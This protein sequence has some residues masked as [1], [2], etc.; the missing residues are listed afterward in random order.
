MPT[1]TEDQPTKGFRCLDSIRLNRWQKIQYCP[2]GLEPS[3]NCGVRGLFLCK[4]MGG[5]GKWAKGCG[6]LLATT[7]G[8]YIVGLLTY[9]CMRQQTPALD[10]YPRWDLAK[11]HP[12][13]KWVNQTVRTHIPQGDCLVCAGPRVPTKPLL[14]TPVP[15]DID[16]CDKEFRE[17]EAWKKH[18]QLTLS[19]QV[20]V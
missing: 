19:Y 4:V 20:H 11:D 8:F 18:G 3:G 14:A 10:E 2:G 13:W 1:V 5:Y 12:W 16:H 9:L 17:T 6:G 7:V 15:Y